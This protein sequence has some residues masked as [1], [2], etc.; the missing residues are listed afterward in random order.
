MVPSSLTHVMD[1]GQS[2]VTPCR[3]TSLPNL[4]HLFPAFLPLGLSFVLPLS[5]SLFL[6]PS[7][8]HFPVNGIPLFFDRIISIPLPTGT[9]SSF[10][11]GH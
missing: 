7:S 9:F 4:G 8:T 11:D 3:S 1:P 6:I 10:T 5:P 2:T